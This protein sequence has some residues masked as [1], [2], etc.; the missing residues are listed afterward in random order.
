MENAIMRMKATR[1]WVKSVERSENGYNAEYTD[2]LRE[3][4]IFTAAQAERVLPELPGC[5]I[6]YLGDWSD[7]KVR[8]GY[9]IFTTDTEDIIP[10]ALFIGRIDVIEA[11][12]SDYEAA[13]QAEADGFVKFI[14]DVDGLEKG[15]YIDTPGNREHCV[16][17]LAKNPDFRV[18]NLIGGWNEAYREK[19]NGYCASLMN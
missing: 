19:Y 15:M 3:V 13:R 18:E 5:V 17:F 7:D 2:S 11:F 16:A 6:L 1:S 14:N 9:D 8:V 4:R 10:D 12:D